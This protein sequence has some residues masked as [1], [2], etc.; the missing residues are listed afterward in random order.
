[1]AEHRRRTLGVLRGADREHAASGVAFVGGVQVRRGVEYLQPRRDQHAER[2]DPHPVAQA[3]QN[4]VAIDLAAS[5]DHTALMIDDNAC[6]AHPDDAQK[7]DRAMGAAVNLK[8]EGS[9]ARVTLDRPEVRN[10][11][12]AEVIGE[13]REIFEQLGEHKSV[14]AVVLSGEGTVFCGGADV[15][16]MRDS[17]ALSF[18][19]NVADAERMGGLALHV[20]KSAISPSRPT[21]PFSGSR[22][23]NS[24]SFPPS[25]PRSC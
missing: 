25:F 18:D 11:F 19:Q 16:W 9:V 2:D 24:A 21:T 7:P 8:I 13:L 4:G 1:M 12:N 22:K 14:R 20:A 17:L 15:N 23:P 3:R 10:A 6:Q 5:L